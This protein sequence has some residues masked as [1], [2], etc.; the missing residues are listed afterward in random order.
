MILAKISIFETV[1]SDKLRVA[2]LEEACASR[3]ASLSPLV[4]L[5]NLSILSFS[6]AFACLA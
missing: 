5:A 3:L 1:A 4:S 2:D 6:I